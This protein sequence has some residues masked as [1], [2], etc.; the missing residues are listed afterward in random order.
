MSE[1]AATISVPV[2]R[3]QHPLYSIYIQRWLK[4]LDLYEGEHL[5][6]YLH[7]HTRESNASFQ[8]RLKRLAYRNYCNPVVD[9]YIHYVFAKKINRELPGGHQVDITTQEG[10][11]GENKEKPQ[12]SGVDKEWEEWLHDVDRNGMNINQFMAKA[13]RYAQVF[14]H[15]FL[16]VDYPRITQDNQPASEAERIAKGFNAYAKLYY[17]TEAPNWAVDDR[18]R[19][20]WIRFREI[21]PD[22]H[23]PFSLPDNMFDIVSKRREVEGRA[24]HSDAHSGIGGT[25]IDLHS[26]RKEIRYRTW[27]RD[28]WFLH[29]VHGDTV[30]LLGKGRHNLGEVPVV[31]LYN[32]E[33]SRHQFIGQSLLVNIAGLNQTILN[34][35]SLINEAEYQSTLNLLVMEEQGVEKD[36]VIIGTNNVLAYSGERPPFFI[37]PSTAPLAFMQNRIVQ[38]REEIYRLA[39]FGGGLGLEPRG[40]PSGVSLAFEFNET[41]AMLSERADELESAEYRMHELWYKWRE[42]EFHGSVDYPD[43]FSIQSLQDDLTLLMTAKRVLRSP[44]ARRELEKQ[45][46][47]RVLKGASPDLINTAEK[48]VDT[49]PEFDLEH[50]LLQLKQA[51]AG[52]AQPPAQPQAQQP[53]GDQEQPPKPAGQPAQQT[54]AQP[55]KE[56][57]VPKGQ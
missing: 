34:L 44:T 28:S 11:A 36:E 13:G 31:P 49:I 22:D 5:D 56:P 20:A 38:F 26:L 35:D 19:L 8:E 9:L 41:N 57:G 21:V 42:A 47:S 4:Y 43:D 37:S 50:Q 55:Q 14:G 15:V 33:T 23:D 3:A 1:S 17:P 6:Q 27:T 52:L 16:L 18:G 45:T 25:R 2:L 39:K 29:K 30:E 48:E 32:R 53:G 51:K 10:M 7:K 12:L 40:A 24:Q 54:Q 46:Q